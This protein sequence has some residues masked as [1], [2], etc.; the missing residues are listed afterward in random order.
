MRW[1]GAPVPAALIAALAVLMLP[2]AAVAAFEG[3]WRVA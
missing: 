3:D 1:R 2:P